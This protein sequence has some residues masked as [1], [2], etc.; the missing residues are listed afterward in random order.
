MHK[1][2]CD[3]H[4]DSQTTHRCR[5]GI[6]SGRGAATSAQQHIQKL[7]AANAAE[8]S[9]QQQALPNTAS[10]Q[11]AICNLQLAGLE[12]VLKAVHAIQGSNGAKALQQAWTRLKTSHGSQQTVK[13]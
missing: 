12:A 5:P 4:H 8:L 6:S 3:L 13:Q 2:I 7:C 10:V 11:Q 9:M 1:V